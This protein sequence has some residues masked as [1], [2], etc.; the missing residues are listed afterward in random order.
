MRVAIAYPPMP[1]EKGVPLLSQN[2]QFQW[3]TRPTYIYPVVPA[4]AATQAKGAG[5]E[6]AWLDGIASGWTP[7]AFE[8]RLDGF[9]PDVVMLETKTPVVSR[10]WAYIR[11]LKARMPGVTVALVGD[12]VTALPEESFRQCPVDFVLTGGDYDFLLL[13]LLACLQAAA[14]GPL[15]CAKLE[16]GIYWRDGVAVRS[17]GAFRLDHDLKALPWIDRE[18][19][20]WR[21]YAEKNGNYRRT[22]G[23]YIMSGRDC[24]HGKCTFCSWTTLYPTYRAR[25]PKDVVNEIGELIGRYGVR[26]IMDDTG[27]LP[28][29]AWLRTFCEE[30]IARG[31]NKRVKIDCNMRFGCLDAETYR[32]MK[33]AGF[34]LVLFGLESANQSTLDRLVKGVTVG[35]IEEGARAA[36]QAGLDVH[37]TVMFGYPWEGEREIAN[38]VCLARKLLRKGYAYTL[39]VTMV[40][41]Y[42]GTPLFRELD[43]AGLLLTRDWDDYDMRRQVMKSGV[44]EEVIKGAVRQVYR[45][46]LHPET[47]LRRLVSTRDPLADLKFYWR[48]FLSLAGHLKD[49][50]G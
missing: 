34:R 33:R 38:T 48:G 45:V 2:R 18:L 27:S 37:V 21:L 25:E 17:N 3:F 32:L 50:R 12:H 28:A 13:N 14:G 20:Q 16:P 42:P 1:S 44:P 11:A 6:V 10:H 24:W 29:G 49:F 35:Q 4:L 19:T 9:A 36:A 43:Q 31:Y 46:F 39:Q 41:P 5:H 47:I 30:M 40:V 8:E 22:P 26:E 7:E 15:D 23:T